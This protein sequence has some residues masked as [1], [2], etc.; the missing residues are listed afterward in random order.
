MGRNT[1]NGVG[2]AQ[3]A[4][5]CLR[6]KTLHNPTPHQPCPSSNSPLH[7]MAGTGQDTFPLPLRL[8]ADTGNWLSLQVADLHLSVGGGLRVSPS[9][10]LAQSSGA[11]FS[12]IQPQ[13]TS[14]FHLKQ[15]PGITLAFLLPSLTILRENGAFCSPSQPPRRSWR[16]EEPWW[17]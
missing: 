1:G 14:G 5:F 3:V 11:R 2:S 4:L 9:L 16:Q 13:I 10:T 7:L 17:R 8:K 12:Q 15:R 6:A